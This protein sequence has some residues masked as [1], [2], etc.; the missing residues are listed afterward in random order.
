[1]ATLALVATAVWL[2]SSS[3]SVDTAAT[4][5]TTSLPSDRSAV[6]TVVEP[7]LGTPGILATRAS[8]LWPVEVTNPPLTSDRGRRSQVYR[9][10]TSDRAVLIDAVR[11]DDAPD[12]VPPVIDAVGRDVGGLRLFTRTADPE[13]TITTLTVDDWRLS[14][15]AIGIDDDELVA[16]LGS[17]RPGR[18]GPTFDDALLP[19][20]DDVVSRPFSAM[21]WFTGAVT[22]RTVY[23]SS[24]DDE[25]ITV[26]V[27]VPDVQT[28]VGIERTV[29]MNPV[30]N[31]WR[32]TGRLAADPSVAVLQYRLDDGRIVT[33][34]GRLTIDALSVRLSGSRVATD[35]EWRA[36]A[37]QAGGG[38][39][40]ERPSNV[41]VGNIGSSTPWRA[42][43]RPAT[44][45]GLRQFS[46]WWESPGQSGTTPLRAV[47]PAI[48]QP[49]YTSMG[50]PGRTYVFVRVPADLG[51][52][53]VE[54]RSNGESRQRAAAT[55]LA[56][57]DIAVAVLVFPEPG[58]FD[59]FLIGPNGDEQRIDTVSVRP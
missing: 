14:V 8:E 37:E 13:R 56:G 20:V 6:T 24:F 21:R 38:A 34:S 16:F 39:L 41:A 49:A 54:L 40:V 15:D 28:S 57:T 12:P 59:V 10:T 9:S 27:G 11:L 32:T 45:F 30:L 33:A 2:A 53:F 46:W 4:S 29:L 52:P 50:Y 1:V 35:A 47:G 43:V 18:L 22:S 36:L 3:S 42:G 23:W 17:A 51:Q 55:P 5:T 19:G 48:R 25:P 44:R 7:Q 31:R 58:P 26:T